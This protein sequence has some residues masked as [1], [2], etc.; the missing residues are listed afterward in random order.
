MF[1]FGLYTQVSDSGPL[2]PLVIV[3]II[4]IGYY[5]YSSNYDSSQK[6]LGYSIY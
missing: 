2:G 3:L 6:E 4:I 1:D 5:Y